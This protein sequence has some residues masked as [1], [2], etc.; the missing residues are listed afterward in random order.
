MDGTAVNFS[1]P[2]ED[3]IAIRELYDQYCDGVM[4][5]DM[6]MW[7]PTWAEDAEWLARGVTITGR[8]NI[9]AAASQILENVPVAIFFSNLGRTH[10]DGNRGTGRCYN[11]ELFYFPS[12]PAYYL[13][14]YDDEYAKVDGRWVFQKRINVVMKDGKF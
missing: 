8:A 11:I 6:A 4:S 13:S 3:R 12:G 9:V 14:Y 7:G 10:I 1:G 5:K 2:L